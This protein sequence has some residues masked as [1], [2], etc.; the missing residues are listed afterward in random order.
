MASPRPHTSLAVLVELL[1]PQRCDKK[2]EVSRGQVEG[3]TSG[4]CVCTLV[5]TPNFPQLRKNKEKTTSKHPEKTSPYVTVHSFCPE[6]TTAH[7]EVTLWWLQ[8]IFYGY[9]HHPFFIKLCLPFYSK[10]LKQYGHPQAILNF[11]GKSRL[12]GIGRGKQV[13][14]VGISWT[15]ALHGSDPAHVCWLLRL[16]RQQDGMSSAVN[17]LVLYS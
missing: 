5:A 9:H 1:W 4:C 2:W 10:P 6:C 3:W 8:L 17:H 14:L 12:L 15:F 7:S 11:F 13:I 16:T